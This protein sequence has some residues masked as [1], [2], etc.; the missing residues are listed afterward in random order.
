MGV[1]G[2]VNPLR[3][4]REPRW[5]EQPPTWADARPGVID[6]ALRRAL[7][8]PAGNWYV[9][10]ASTDLGTRRP[11]GRTVAGT[12]LVVW[13][14]AE[15]APHAG[16]GACP[17]LGAPLCD[18]RLAGGRL[19]CHWHGLALDGGGRPGWAPYPCHDD[20]V[21]LWV[22]LDE[23]GAESPLPAPVLAERP[24]AAAAVA[25]AVTLVGRCEPADVLANRLDP[26]HG[27]WYHPYS[28]ANLRVLAAP[29]PVDGQ[30][31]HEVA[32][33]DD[34]FL[35]EVAFRVAG[36]FGVPVIAEFTC[37]DRRTV[38][39]RILDGD[40]AG[41][42]VETHATPIGT[43]PDGL[44]RTAV[45]EATIAHS[46]RRGFAVA[47]AAAP[48]LRPMIRHAAARLWRDDL[49]YAERRYLLRS[50]R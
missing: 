31:D 8:R 48:L 10:G 17:H 16:P 42:V 13:R 38:L 44:P 15:G 39:M 7:S 24:P 50:G 14:D 47:R 22:R 28:F 12:E 23:V 9:I 40:G 4:L 41:S 1:I 36:P 2:R 46:D 26:W 27:S 43:G 32:E 11:V 20:G 29:G 18:S 35:V 30:V 33:A 45:V 19:V 25:E 37:P 3:R 34:R 6:A 49:A 5:P 21:L